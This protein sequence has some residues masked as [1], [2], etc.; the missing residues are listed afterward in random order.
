MA[1]ASSTFALRPL[2]TE[3]FACYG[4]AV[5]SIYERGF[6]EVAGAGEQFING[7]LRK[8]MGYTGF[9][10]LVAVDADDHA[11]GFVYGYHS[12]PGQYWREWITPDLI[13]LG[14]ESWLDDVFEFVE[15]A[16][17]PAF[18]GQG[19]GSCLHDALLRATS[20][21]RSLLCAEQGDGVAPTMYRRRGWVPLVPNFKGENLM[22]MGLDLVAFRRGLSCSAADRTIGQNDRPQSQRSQQ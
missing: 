8:H 20:E 15:F 13:A 14:L 17:D 9:R 16:V 7:Q 19:I 2:T 1:G 12:E 6:N 4:G 11:V 22:V 18:Q 21:R 10:G 3:T 5:A